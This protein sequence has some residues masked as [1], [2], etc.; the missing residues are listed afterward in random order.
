ME[1]LAAKPGD[2]VLGLREGCMFIV[3]GNQMK[4]NGKL[5]V[6]VFRFNQDPIELDDS[7]D[8]SEF[9]E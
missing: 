5:S 3:E 2:T 7:F 1:Y 4:L 9:L 8:F 6:R